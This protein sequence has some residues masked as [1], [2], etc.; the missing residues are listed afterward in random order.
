M[1]TLSI[2]KAD[3]GGF[4][5]HSAVHP[6]M[7]HAAREWLADAVNT[8]LLSDGQ[9]ASCGDDL[10]LIMVHGHGADAEAV[11]SFAWELFQHTTSIAQ[12]LGLYGAGQD[13]LSDAF[14]GNLRGMGP[15]YAELE[16][17]ER[18]SEPMICFL[19]DKTEPGAW[20]LPLYRMFADPFNTAGLV[21]D[22]NMHPGFLFEVYDLHEEK[23]IVFDCP[24]ELYDM[25]MYIGAPARYVV[26]RIHSKTL[27]ATAAATSTQRLSLIAGKYVGKDDP[28]MIVRC[29]SGL[30]AVGE[31]LEPFAFPYTVAGCMRGSH[32]APL[33]PVGLDQ[34]HPTRFDGPPRVVA[35]GFQVT[36]GKLVGPRDLFADPSFDRARQQANVTMDYLRRHGPFEPHRLP[37]EDLEYTTMRQLEDDLTDRWQP[38]HEAPAPAER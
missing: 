13:L 15:G 22:K 14:S 11:H 8:G 2:I 27:A 7:E 10:A 19:A 3:T 4:V 23:R 38:I 21:I 30:P 18:P 1:T 37:L 12:R 33:M 31:V 28:V 9:V 26:H 32:H 25:L 34:A 36:D 17:T 6:D 35:L 24:S 16:F 29:Q 5:G 20:N